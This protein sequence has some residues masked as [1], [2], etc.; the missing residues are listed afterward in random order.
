MKPTLHGSQHTRSERLGPE[1]MEKN[2]VGSRFALSQSGKLS[3]AG[4]SNF[5]RS[6]SRMEHTSCAYHRR[7]CLL[8]TTDCYLGSFGPRQSSSSSNS[9][10]RNM[11]P[12][13]L[14]CLAQ[15]LLGMAERLLR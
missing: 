2:E 3:S 11:I 8:A 10:L 14:A 1:D 6:T 12:W 13:N 4:L 9:I 15:Q 5:D 7:P